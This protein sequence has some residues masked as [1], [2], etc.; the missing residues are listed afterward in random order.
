MYTVQKYTNTHAHART[1]KM[2]S[3]FA[4]KEEREAK[5]FMK[6]TEI[7]LFV[8]ALIRGNSMDTQKYTAFKYVK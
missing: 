1:H 2:L 7:V 3:S 6:E 5:M 8:F 4:D